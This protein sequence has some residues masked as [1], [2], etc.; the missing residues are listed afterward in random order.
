MVNQIPRNRHAPSDE[1]CAEAC[2][3]EAN[4]CFSEEA[5]MDN[6]MNCSEEFEDS[7]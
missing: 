6:M 3:D 5:C 1:E 7:E 4:A 2:E